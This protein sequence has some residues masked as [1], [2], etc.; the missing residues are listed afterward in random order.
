MKSGSDS[1]EEQV[2]IFELGEQTYGLDILAV[3][4]I[5]HTENITKIPAA[6]DFIAGIINLRGNII[7]VI[8]LSRRFG[9]GTENSNQ[10]VE[11]TNTRIIVLQVKA[12]VFGVIV[13][14][15]HEVLRIPVDI[16][17]PPPKVVTGTLGNTGRQIDAAYL[18]GIAKLDKKLIILLNHNKILFEHETEELQQVAG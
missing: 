13:D 16:I 18:N 15:V 11:N 5:I 10:E 4:E 6:P 12:T 17:E 8:D 3:Q 9:I 1:G 7:P 2:V 14:S